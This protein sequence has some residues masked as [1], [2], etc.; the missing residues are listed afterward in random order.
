M[1]GSVTNDKFPP[2]PM[3]QG[4]MLLEVYTHK[5]LGKLAGLKDN[6]RYVVLGTKAFELAVTQCV[7]RQFP[8]YSSKE[9][10]VCFSTI[11]PDQFLKPSSF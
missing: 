3:L 7:F 6:E 1:D 8:H 10:E 2:L 11:Y 9:I 4:E 5:S